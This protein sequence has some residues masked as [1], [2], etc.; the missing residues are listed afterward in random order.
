MSN[1]PESFDDIKKFFEYNF[2]HGL[3]TV[4]EETAKDT[5]KN[6]RLTEII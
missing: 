6:Q 2:A 4:V 1:V 5:V 3:K